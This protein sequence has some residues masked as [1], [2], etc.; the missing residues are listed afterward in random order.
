[1]FFRKT[2]LQSYFALQEKSKNNQPCWVGVKIWN[3]EM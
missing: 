1:M 3:D 2:V